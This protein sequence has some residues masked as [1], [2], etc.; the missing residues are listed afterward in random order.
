MSFVKAVREKVWIKWLLTGVSG[1]GKSYSALL[2]ASGV[3]K[4][5]NS[6]IAVISSEGSRTLYYADKFDYDVLELDDYSPESYIKAIDEA[7]A[8]GYK[9]IVIDT[10]SS[11]WQWLNEYH[12]NMPGNSFQNWGRLKPRHK[13]FMNKVLHSEA[14]VICTARGK[15]EWVLEENEKGKQTP[16]KVGLGSEQD[17]QVS[18]EFTV[19]MVI[20]QARHIAVADKDNTGLFDGKYEV[21]TQRHGELMYDWANAGERQQTFKPD[22][23]VADPSK[24]DVSFVIK[25]IIAKCKELG[26]SSNEKLMATLKQYTSNGNPMSIK[27]IKVAN[28]CLKAIENM[29]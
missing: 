23:P 4:K 26:G 3:A 14:H 13:A 15:T 9:V 18:F 19:S 28:D 27:D 11:E 16:K 5:C 7:V 10:I 22:V 29:S 20:D 2:V 25:E 1:C 6:R 24:D 17:K 21:L 8:A 12:D